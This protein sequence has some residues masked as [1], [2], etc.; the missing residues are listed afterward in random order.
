ML[1]FQFRDMRFELIDF[2]LV[3]VD[4]SLLDLFFDGAVRRKHTGRGSNVHSIESVNRI[5]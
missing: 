4:I 2:F 3:F 5:E 1:F